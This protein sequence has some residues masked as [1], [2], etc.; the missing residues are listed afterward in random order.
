[1]NNV[2]GGLVH[3][4]A[5]RDDWT[6]RPSCAVYHCPVQFWEPASVP[7]EFHVH[8]VVPRLKKNAPAPAVKVKTSMS[9]SARGFQLGKAWKF[10][11]TLVFSIGFPV[12]GI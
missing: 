4:S 1:M 2:N 8:W 9:P 7:T 6:K 10:Q 11:K 12:Y 3:Q 5:F